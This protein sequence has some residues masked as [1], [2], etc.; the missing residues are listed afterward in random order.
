MWPIAE[1][2]TQEE[3]K[4][5]TVCRYMEGWVELY[6]G[7]AHAVCY[8]YATNLFVIN[9]YFSICLN[10]VPVPVHHWNTYFPPGEK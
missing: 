8:V 3:T 1:V 6:D 5:H 9:L 10:P 2:T 7:C 4:Q